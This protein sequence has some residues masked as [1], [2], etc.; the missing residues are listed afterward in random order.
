MRDIQYVD[1]WLVLARAI[2]EER[3]IFKPAC[4]TNSLTNAYSSHLFDI[5]QMRS[6]TVTGLRVT[7]ATYGRTVRYRG[8]VAWRRTRIDV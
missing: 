1:Q 5:I 4:S 3:G 2:L 8:L 6:T 7:L